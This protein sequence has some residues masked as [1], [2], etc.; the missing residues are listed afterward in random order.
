MEYYK[1]VCMD[2]SNYNMWA[3]GC[4]RA[5]YTYDKSGDVAKAFDWYN[6]ARKQYHD[7]DSMRKEQAVLENMGGIYVKLQSYDLAEP[8]FD[9]ALEVNQRSGDQ[10]EIAKSLRDMG[11]VIKHQGGK[12]I[13]KSL[14]Y[15]HQSLDI[16][17]D[18]GLKYE[19]A[20][21]MID[22][23]TVHREVEN[24]GKAREYY[25][26]AMNT[27]DS[28]R[29]TAMALNNISLLDQLS[30]NL[31][32][33]IDNVSQSIALKEQWS[34]IR[35]LI[36]SYNRLGVFQFTA[37]QYDRAVESL[38]TALRYNVSDNRLLSKKEFHE[39]YTYL[40]YIA[41]RT[42]DSTHVHYAEKVLAKTSLQSLSEELELADKHARVTAEFLEERTAM[43]EKREDL[44]WWISYLV[45]FLLVLALVLYA[46]YMLRKRHNERV[47]QEQRE[48]M[49][50]IGI[51]KDQD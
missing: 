23:G 49:K 4:F 22:I 9:Q 28:E 35:M 37:G 27:V 17:I 7:L 25:F 11:L 12:R 32:K 19:M 6:S 38:R 15:F 42:G 43:R 41:Q 16:F 50:R 21:T 46:R 14:E 33:A 47:I 30:G 40:D 1:S 3:K 10:I 20:S 36:D 29:I 24:Y 26:K 44:I 5:G 51:E 13:L 2:Q 31:D 45:I 8:Y 18:L 48:A 39:T 34:D